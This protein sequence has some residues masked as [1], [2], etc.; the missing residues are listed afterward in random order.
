M[1]EHVDDDGTAQV[2]FI[3]YGNVERGV[4]SSRL[5]SLPVALQ[6]LQL[7]MCYASD[8]FPC[9]YST[10]RVLNRVEMHV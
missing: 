6:G 9:L 7:N 2:F 4:G 1:V 5:K 3:D 8:R 10:S